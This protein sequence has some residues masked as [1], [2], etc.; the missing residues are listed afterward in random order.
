MQLR[1]KS[2]LQDSEPIRLKLSDE[3]DKNDTFRYT[4]TL[5]FLFK[6]PKHLG[7]KAL[8][9]IEVA[10]WQL[11][12]NFYFITFKI[13]GLLKIIVPSK[14]TNV[15][16]LS[17]WSPCSTLLKHRIG[18]HFQ[19]VAGAKRSQIQFDYSLSVVISFFFLIC[20]PSIWGRFEKF[21]YMFIPKIGEDFQF[22][23]YFSDGWLRHQPVNPDCKVVIFIENHSWTAR[24]VD[25]LR[26]LERALVGNRR[27]KEN[28]ICNTCLYID[29]P[30]R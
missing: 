7:F 18:A 21:P 2:N 5:F 9:V 22:D 4:F 3:D 10:Y 8:I 30:V 26:V 19:Q 17:I 23:E 14:R 16:M 25:E 1:K 12:Y 28:Y 29:S 13:F 24:F 11:V 15:K 20:S 27:G 6:G